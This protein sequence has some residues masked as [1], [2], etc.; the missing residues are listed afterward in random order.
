VVPE[1]LGLE[2]CGYGLGM[3]RS[4]VDPQDRLELATAH[5]KGGFLAWLD[6]RTGQAGVL[7]LQGVD[8]PVEAP[9]GF[10]AVRVMERL[11]EA[12]KQP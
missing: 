1:G 8:G 7:S 9:R 12:A 11:N 10:D 2:V 4:L 5:G 6:R 3:W